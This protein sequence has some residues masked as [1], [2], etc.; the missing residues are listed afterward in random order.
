MEQE[1]ITNA[2]ISP[3]ETENKVFR[4]RTRTNI[5][6]RFEQQLISTL[7]EKV[8]QAVTSNMLTIIGFA[9]SLIVLTCFIL[10]TYLHSA[11]LLIGIPGLIINWI[12]DSLDGRL[13]YY[14]NIPRKWYGFAL[15]IIMDWASIVLTGF[16]YIIYAEGN[17]EIPGFLFVVLYGWAMIISQL[18]YKITGEYTID[19]G[20]VGPT[21]LRVIISAILIMEVLL[22]GSIIYSATL[23]SFI[24]FIINLVDTSKLLKAGDLRDNKERQNK[25]Y[26]N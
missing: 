19:S 5:F 4:D 8:P 18:R 7:V 16:G 25:N 1:E 3:K 11:Y 13:A 6:W 23:I 17:A 12:G 9:G 24:L 2:K 21:E 22:K 14:R 26:V 15:D 20:L 10:A